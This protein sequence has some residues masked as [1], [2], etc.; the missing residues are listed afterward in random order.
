AVA[1]LALLTFAQPTIAEAT[2]QDDVVNITISALQASYGIT[3][4]Q[5]NYVSVIG[6]WGFT[7]WTAGQGGGDTLMENIN[8]TW[9]VLSQG[10]GQMNSVILVAFGVPQ[11][12]ANA[13]LVGSC[14]RGL[15]KTLG[16]S[17]P[18]SGASVFVRR[19]DRS[20]RRTDSTVRCTS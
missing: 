13:L 5:V 16:A 8:G 4:V 15:R 10:H 9:N 7:S 14:P 3:G 17:K 6:Q 1:L 20:G 2:V 11:A 19:T 18:P 12:T